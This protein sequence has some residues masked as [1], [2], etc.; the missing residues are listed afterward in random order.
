MKEGEG[1]TKAPEPGIVV[2][3]IER[4]DEMTTTVETKTY[5]DELRDQLGSKYGLRLNSYGKTTE[6]LINAIRERGLADT[7]AWSGYFTDA[8][9]GEMIDQAR[10]YIENELLTQ[11]DGELIRLLDVMVIH[12]SHFGVSTGSLGIPQR[13]MEMMAATIRAEVLNEAKQHLIQSAE[14]AL[15]AIVRERFRDETKKVDDL[16]NTV[17]ELR[18]KYDRARSDSTKEKILDE[19][20]TASVHYQSAAKTLRSSILNFAMGLVI[21]ERLP[22]ILNIEAALSYDL[23]RL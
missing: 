1:L 12:G 10:E 16:R 18:Q 15:A 14:F 11:D 5:A 2:V 8:L 13:P 20:D 22:V 6:D 17:R 7:M 9:K 21:S 3:V 19:I 4:G 23:E